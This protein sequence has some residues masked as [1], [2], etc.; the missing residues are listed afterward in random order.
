M[1][2]STFI[3]LSGVNF[4]SA[5][6]KY[7]M[8]TLFQISVYLPQWHEGPQS[9]PHLGLPSS[10]KISVSGPQGPVCPAGPHQLSAF[11]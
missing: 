8:K 6:L 11:P 10:K 7:C 5:S 9:G 3:C 4:P 1:P 2:V